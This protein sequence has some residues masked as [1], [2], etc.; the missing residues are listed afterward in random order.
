MT[1]ASVM[2]LGPRDR[3]LA[4][5]Q[6]GAFILAWLILFAPMCLWALANALYVLARRI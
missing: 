3:V 2:E 5:M 4:G 1:Q 6:L